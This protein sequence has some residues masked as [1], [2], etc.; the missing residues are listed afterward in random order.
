[1]KNGAE[2]KDSELGSIYTWIPRY[3]YNE[4]NEIV[5]LKEQST[6][7][8]TWI[9][10]ELFIL[11]SDSREFSLSGVWLEYNYLSSSEVK[12]KINNMNTEE[13]TYGFISNTDAIEM[14]SSYQ[15]IIQKYLNQLSNK[16]INDIDKS[17]LID[18][19]NI[20]R[21][22]LR[23]VDTNKQE[24]IQAEANY[25]IENENVK[26][27]INIIYSKNGIKEIIDEDGNIVNNY[28]KDIPN[29]SAIEYKFYIID[30]ENNIIEVSVQL[31]KH[32][33]ILNYDNG[34]RVT[35]TKPTPYSAGSNYIKNVNDGYTGK[36]SPIN[37]NLLHSQDEFWGAKNGWNTQ[38]ALENNDS[39][40]N[41]NLTHD[42]ISK[43]TQSA[44]TIYVSGNTSTEAIVIIDP[45]AYQGD[46][47]KHLFKMSECYLASANSDGDVGK[48]QIYV[49]TSKDSSVATNPNDS[50]WNLVTSGNLT[51]DTVLTKVYDGSVEFRYIKLVLHCR[52]RSYMELAAIK[53]Y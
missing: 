11:K 43:S 41:I 27:K 6:V 25:E 47:S 12:N 53:V 52:R 49:S 45:R 2:V 31:L 40:E 16:A 3:A 20:N 1:M 28:E 7:I 51:Q 32:I 29:Y 37:S 44:T 24:P 15:T 23:T 33:N 46:I 21:T 14:T 36:N 26:V 10:P 50:S 35:Y 8:G 30:N 38:G 42:E 34:A 39:K 4:N 18:I 17:R 19:T 48:Y 22:I 9:M 13:N 5:Y